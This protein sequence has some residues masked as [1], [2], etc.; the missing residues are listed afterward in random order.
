MGAPD[1]A[2]GEVPV[3]AVRLVDGAVVAGDE[4][5]AW[6]AERLADYKAPRRVVIVDDLPKTGTQKVR[7][8]ELLALF[9]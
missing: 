9:D 5:V 7:R 3:A 6:V 8:Q 2:R 4:L 1:E